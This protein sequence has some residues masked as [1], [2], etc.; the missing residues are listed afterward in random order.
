MARPLKVLRTIVKVVSI[1]VSLAFIINS[2]NGLLSAISLA[3]NRSISTGPVQPGDFQL[4]Y[5]FQK[6][7]VAVEVHNTAM[8]D[9]EGILLRVQFDVGVNGT[10]INVLDVTSREV[11]PSIPPEGQTIKAGENATIGLHITQ[12]HFNLTEFIAVVTPTPPWTLEDLLTLPSPTDFEARITIDFSVK[13][14]FGQYQL[15]A[16]LTL[17]TEKVLE[18]L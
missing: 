2:A 8:Y 12:E 10:W 14:A 9:L 13:Y 3:E 15:A 16:R 7:D 6:V 17:P 18:G 11:D 5:D 1:A 4:E